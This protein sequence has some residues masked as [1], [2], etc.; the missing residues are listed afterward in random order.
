MD[1]HDC[2]NDVQ[3]SSISAVNLRFT[4]LLRERSLGVSPY[5]TQ[6]LVC[7]WH[8]CSLKG[9]VCNQQGCCTAFVRGM[10]SNC[11]VYEL[12]AHAHA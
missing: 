6:S 2:A 4:Q 12:C 3:E 11:G 5:D 7:Q 9:H 10:Q 8:V 1:S